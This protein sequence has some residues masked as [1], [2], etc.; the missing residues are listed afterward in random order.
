MTRDFT[1]CIRPRSFTMHAVEGLPDTGAVKA[2]CG[3]GCV[4]AASRNGRFDTESRSYV[5]RGTCRRCW[6]FVR[7]R[8]LVERRR[9]EGSPV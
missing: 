9:A 7:K 2:L 3:A 5:P 8:R 6:G 1:I 4:V